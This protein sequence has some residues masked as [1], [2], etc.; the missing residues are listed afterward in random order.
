MENNGD[1]KFDFERRL[2]WIR[3][4]DNS[5]I[6]VVIIGGGITGAGIANIL[7]ENGIKCLLLEKNDF[8]SGTSSGST[9][10]VHGGIRYLANFEIG[11]VR[12]LLRERNYLVKNTDIVKWM[13]FRILV[14]KYSWKKFTL[15]AG[16]F[17]Y[18]ILSGS[19]R[20]PRF[21]KNKGQY[22]KDI[23]GYFN[24]SDAWTDDTKL[25]IYNIASAVKHG[26]IC[27]N[28][29]E[30]L[31][32]TESEDSISVKFRDRIMN[33][34]HNV[35]GKHL[36]NGAGPWSGLI[37][38]MERDITES[39]LKLSKGI[40]IVVPSQIINSKDSIVFRSH[41]DRRQ[42]FAVPRGE[43]TII[44]TT[45]RFVESPDDFKIN[46]EDI[47]YIIESAV[48]LF[49]N[50]RESD[51]TYAYA[52]IRP[53]YGESDEPGSI[54]RGFVIKTSGRFIN[55]FGGKLTNYRSVSRKVGKIYEKISGKRIK[56]K[57]MPEISYRRPN[58]Q[59]KD[60]YRY[61]RDYECAIYP[62]DIIVRREAMPFNYVDC[63]RSIS[64]EV[65]KILD[66][67][68][69]IKGTD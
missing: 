28:Y 59:G 45:D 50:L 2:Q 67:K 64:S 21:I 15:R 32:I 40:H 36:I 41:I 27:L 22:G 51:I 12:D 10:L 38:N 18:N 23:K 16:I 57:G 25:V 6:D 43:V 44:G 48:R 8:A 9:K 37:E 69:W 42:M 4:L 19:P 52:G 62:D 54:S 63:G 35:T 61:E 58:L 20:I 3:D 13:N 5:Q 66:E 56:I 1:S 47:K 29:C 11:E 60:L 31:N 55:V 30:A 14:D 17:V 49:P 39:R 65:R 24:Y 53:L 46:S 26:A 33:T 34:E 7:S 68:P